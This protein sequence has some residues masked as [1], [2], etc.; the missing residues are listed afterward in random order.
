[1]DD[2]LI[3][4][5]VENEYATPTISLLQSVMVCSSTLLLTT[6]FQGNDRAETASYEIPQM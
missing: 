6:Q 1:M 2:S 4:S 5:H 3:I